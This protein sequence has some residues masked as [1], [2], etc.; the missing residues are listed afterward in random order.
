MT[1]TSVDD[2]LAHHGVLGMKWGRHKAGTSGG[3]G[4]SSSSAKSVAT[5][6]IDKTN[7]VKPT[8]Q[9]VT[10]AQ[11]KEARLRQNLRA[12]TVNQHARDLLM[13]TSDKGRAHAQK[14]LDKSAD[15]LINN[16]DAAVA[17]RMTAGEKFFGTV[18]AGLLAVSVG[19][20][21]HDIAKM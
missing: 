10:S 13:Q 19:M 11:I 9:K 20:V 6:K 12:E 15:Q 16:P 2:F 7:E 4:G 1:D 14:V 3:G 21:V 5:K 17:N 18:G 8:K